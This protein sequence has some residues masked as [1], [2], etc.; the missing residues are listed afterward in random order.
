MQAK[1]DKRNVEDIISLTSMQEGMLFHYI[2]EPDSTEYH[3]QINIELSG[4]INL[5]L[6]KK[7]WSFV[8]ETNEMLRTIYRWKNIDKPVQ[9]V[10]KNHEVIIQNYNLSDKSSLEKERFLDEIK[11]VDLLNRIDLEKETLRI[12]LCKCAE[13]EYTM[14]ISNHHILYDGWS[15]AIIIKELLSVYHALHKGLVLEAPSK[16]KFKEYVK[17][18]HAQDKTK[19]KEYWEN[20]LCELEQNDV[21]FC[22]AEM[23]EDKN[24]KY[25]LSNAVSQEIKKF[26]KEN[27]ISV[28]AFLYC[29]WGILAQKLNNTRDILFGATTSGRSQYING[30]ENMVGLFINTIPMRINTDENET[31]IKLIKKT[32][33]ALQRHGEFE[34]TP[35]VDIKKY[36]KLSNTAQL[37][38]SL[39]VIENYPLDISDLPDE[40]LKITNY[41][42]IE[43]TNYNLT[44]GITIL[45]SID[46]D[47]QYKCFSDDGMIVR[48]AQYF[49]AVISAM[50][51]DKNS[52]IVD[53]EI[54]SE[55]ERNQ[56][57]YDFNDTC[58]EYPQ[59]K[60]IHKLFEEQVTKTPKNTAL[61]C[62]NEHMSY[63]ELNHRANRIASI[64]HTKGVGSDTIVGIMAERSFELIIGMLGVLKAGGAYVSIDPEYP[65]DRI[66]FMI[67]DSGANILLTQ[68]RFG[69]AID[70][71][72]ETIN[73]DDTRLYE[74]NTENLDI[75]NN[76]RDLAYIIYTSGSTG[77]PKGVMIEHR[78]VVNLAIGQIKTYK[79][80]ELDRVLQFYSASFDASVEQIFTTLL[81]GAALYLV[82]KDTL[83]NHSKFNALLKN[84]SITHLD[85][86]P[87]F[88]EN[89]NLDEI[90]SLKRVISGGEI[91]HSPLAK[92]LCQKLEFYNG[93]G[94]TEA[95][96]TSTMYLMNHNDEYANIP[97]GKPISN[98]QTYILNADGKPSPLGTPGE[99][100]IS[101]DGLAR[102]YLNNPEL[103]SEKFVPNPF[104]PN[105]R[106]YRTGDLAR[107]LPCGNIEFLGRV[108]HQ[109]K[110]RGFRIEIGEVESQLIALASVKEAAIAVKEDKYGNKYLCAYVV[111]N[112][113]ASVNELR[114]LLSKNLP[115]YMIPSHF[116]VINSL[117]LTSSGKIDRRALPEP[118]GAALQVE[119]VAPQN[120]TEEVLAKIWSEILGIE[121]VGIKDNFFDLGG[122]SL[123]GTILVSRI[124]KEFNIELPLKE[125]FKKPTIAEISEYILN[126]EE[127]LHLE[128]KPIESKEY[129]MTSAAQKRMWVLQQLDTNNTTYNMT[130]VLILDGILNKERLESTFIELIHRHEV[131]RTSFDMVDGN[132]V[133]RVTEKVDFNIKYLEDMEENIENQIKD[134]VQPFDLKKAPL[135]RASLIKTN[136]NQHFLLFDMHHIISDGVSVTTLTREFMALYDGQSFEAQKI[137]YK[138][139]AEWQNEFLKSE[140]VLKQEKY[141]LEQFAGEIPV[142]NLPLDY[143]RPA[144]QEFAGDSIKF[145]LDNELVEKLKMISKETGATLYM[146][147]LSAINIL[148]SKYSGQ[149]DIIIG[150]FI[151]GRPHA[152]LKTMLGMFINTIAMRNYPQGSK[153]YAEFLNDVKATAL[154]AYENQDYPFEDMVDKLNIH[155]DLSRTPLFD[156]IFVLQNMEAAELKLENL[157]LSEYIANQSKSQI[158]LYFDAKEVGNEILF[159]I[160]YRTSLFKRET[161]ERLCEHLQNVLEEISENSNMLLSDI[162]ILSTAERQKVLYEFN[163]TIME[164]PKDKTINQLF[165]DRVAEIP[166]KTALIFCDKVMTYG[167]LNAKA[168]QIARAL[169]R[170]NV[171]PDELVGIM[172]E[173]SFEMIIGILGILKAGGAYVPI[174]PEYPEDRIQFMLKDSGA[175]ILLTQS[176]LNEIVAFEGETINLDDDNVYCG[177]TTNLDIISDSSNLAYVLYTSGSTGVPKG[178]MME[179]ISTVNMLAGHENLYPVEAED[180]YLLKTAYTFDMGLT[181][182]FGWFIGDGKCVILE[183]GKEKEPAEILKIVLEKNI[184]HIRFVPSVLNMFMESV[185]CDSLS[186]ASSLKYIHVAG[187]A[188]SGNIVDK[189]YR[190][191][192]NVRIENIYGPTECADSTY[193]SANINDS[194]QNVPI[195]KPIQNYKI[196]ILDN[197]S[198]PLPIGIPG[199]L[200]IS[201]IG[202]ARGYLNRDELTS[203]KFVP[204]L[205]LSDEYMYRTGDLARWLPDGNIEFLG[206]IDHQVKIRGFRVEPGEIESCLL[207]LEFVKDAVVL[208]FEDNTGGKYLCAYIVSDEKIST[209]ELRICLSKSLPDYMIP[210]H[211]VHLESIPLTSNGKVDRK[212]LPLPIIDIGTE[213]VAPRDTIEETLARVWCEVL[214]REIVGIYDNFF[215]LGGHSLKGT[216]LVSRIHKELNVELPLKELFKAPTISGIRE[217]IKDA[218]ISVYSSIEPI[219]NKAYYETSSA[220]KRMFLLHQ[221][222]PNGIGYNMP[223][224][225]IL[226]GVLDIDQLKSVFMELINR[227]E[228]LRTSF[229]M[230][231]D[232]IVQKAHEEFSFEI[233][234]TEADENLTTEE[235]RNFIKPFDL[236]KAPLLRVGLVKMSENRHLLLFDMHHIISDGTS[237]VILTQ[238]FIEL[239]Q[240][241]KLEKLKIQYKDFAE[242]QNKFLKSK[243]MLA[244]E[245]Y[246][247]E[248]LSGEIPVLN[249]PLDYVRPAVKSFIGDKIR[250]VLDVDLTKKLRKISMETGTTL[251]MTLLSSINILLMQYTGQEDIIIGSPIAGRKHTDL[252]GIIG[253]FV[254]T[255][256]MRNYPIG[257]KTYAEFLKEVKETALQAFTNQDYQF[258]ELVDKLNLSRDLSRNPLFDVMFV[259]QNMAAANVEIDRLR[260]TGYDSN[261]A[262]AKFDLT[263]TAEEMDDEISFS[264]EYCVS[265][266]KRETIERMCGHLQRIFVE[267]TENQEI[268]LMDIDMLSPDERNRILYEFNNTYAEFPKDKTIHQLFEEQVKKTPDNVAL[269][270]EDRSITYSELNAKS[271]QLARMLRVSGVDS[272]GLVGI[273]VERSFEMIIGILGILKAGGAYV[274]IDPEYPEERIKFMLEDSEAE[275]LLTQSWLEDKI[276]FAGKKIALDEE[277]THLN[278][279]ANLEIINNPKNLACVIYTSGSTGAPKGVM[280][281][282]A[283]IV[284]MLF[285][286]ERKYPLLD[287]DAYLLKTPYTFDFSTSEIFG[288]FVG[289]G[290]LVILSQGDEKN[291]KEIFKAIINHDVTHMNLVTPMLNVFIDIISADE[292]NN[293]GRLKYLFVG[294]EALGINCVNKFYLAFKGA[295]LE[296]VY[297]PTETSYTTT[298]STRQDESYITTPIGKPMANYI[299]YILNADN[300]L[301]PLNI[302][303]E[304][305]I[306]GV[307]LA[308]GYLKRSELTDEKFVENPFVPGERMYRTGD[309]VRWLP[310]GNIEFLGRIDHQ[311]KIRGFRIELGEIESKLFE[312]E[313]VKEAVVL[314]HEDDRGDKYLCAYIATDEDI[315]VKELRDHLSKNLPD[316]MIPSYF[317]QLD[318]MPLTPN[319][320]TDRKALPAPEG[321]MILG[322]EYEAPRNQTEEILAGI[323]SEILGV[324]RIGIHDNFFELGGHSLKG[325]ILTSK[326]HKELNVEVPLKELFKSPTIARISEYIA[327]LTKSI[328]STIEPIEERE[329]YETSSAQ[330]RMWLLRQFD[331]EGTSYNMPGVFV[332]DGLLDMERIKSAFTGLIMRHEAL[333][334]SFEMIDDAIVQKIAE[335]VDFE[336]EYAEAAEENIDEEIKEFLHS[337]DLSKAPL[338]RVKV[339]R[340]DE[341]RHYLLFDMHHIISDGTSIAILM[342]EFMALYGGKKLLH[343]K[344]QYKDFSEWQNKLLKSEK[345]QIQEKYWLDKFADDIPILNLPLDYV[346]PIVQSFKGDNISFRLD[347]CL[348]K[349]LRNIS[350]ETGTTLYMILL[351]AI[352]ILLSKYTGQEDIIV[353]SPIAGRPHP[354]LENIIGMFV[355]TLAMRSY[356]SSEKS[357]VEFLDSVKEVAL[358]AYENQDYQFEEL[359]DKLNLSR[360]LSRNPLFDV[361]FVLQNMESVVL[362]IKNLKFTEYYG[363]QSTAKFD[364]TF[365]AL[366][367]KEELVLSIEYCTSLFKKDTIERMNKHL[368]NLLSAISEN[369]NISLGDIEIISEYERNLILHEF[370]DTYAEYPKDKTIHQLFEEQ[371]KKSPNNVAL[372]CENDK[373]SYSELN[374]KSNQ[375]AYTLR[376]KG[377]KPDSIV[378][379]MVERS[380]EM[381]IG[382]LGILKAGG[383]YVPIDPEYPEERIKFM[384]KDSGMKILLTQSH[385]DSSVI[386][387][388]EKINLDKI[389]LYEGTYKNLSTI[390]NPRDIAYVI[391]TSGSTGKPKGVIVEHGNIV[392]FINCQ[393]QRTYKMTEQDRVL[394]SSPISFDP[395]IEQIFIALLSGAS[396]YLIDTERLLDINKFHMF[397]R[398]NAITYLYHVPSYLKNINFEELTDLRVVVSGGEACPVSLAKSLNGKFE[399][400]NGYGPAEATVKSAMYL[401]NP[402]L[403]ETSVPIGKPVSNASIHIVDKNGKLQP[404]CIPGEICISGFGVARG[405]LNHP[406][407]TDEKFVSNPF[408]PNERMYCTGD[409]AKW[410]PDGNIEFLGRID[411]Q[412][413]IRGFRIELGEIEN[414]LL[415]MEIVKEAIILAKEDESG[416]KCLCAYIVV[417]E[418]IAVSEVQ[419]YLSQNLPNYMIPSYIVKLENMPLNPSGKVDR[420]LLPEPK[421]DTDTRYVAPRNE[422]EKALVSIWREV[423]NRDC[424][425]I[426][427]NF[428]EIGGDSIKAILI[429]SKLRDAGYQLR[430]TDLMTSSIF[431]LANMHVKRLSEKIIY[432]QGEIAG[433]SPLTPIQKY[434]L[435]FR[436]INKNHFNQAM[437]LEIMEHVK[438][439][440]IIAVLDAIV[441]HHDIFRAVYRNGEQEILSSHE[442]IGYELFVY[443]YSKLSRTDLAQEI[444]K[445]NNEIQSSI[446]I[447]KGPLMK[448]GLFRTNST[449]HFMIC[450]HHLISDGVSRR[451]LAEDFNTGLRQCRLGLEICL[452][453]KTASYKDWGEELRDYC[454]SKELLDEV[455]Y[456]KHIVN[457][458]EK[459]RIQKG[460]TGKEGVGHIRVSLDKELTDKLLYKS[461][462]IYEVGI[463][464]ILLSSLGM[465]IRRLTSQDKLGVNLVGHGRETINKK[466]ELDRTVGWF[467]IAYP[468][469]IEAKNNLKEVIIETKEMLR[470]IPNKGIGYGALFLLHEAN[471]NLE[472]ADITLNYMGSYDEILGEYSTIFRTSE[473]STGMS[474]ASENTQKVAININGALVNEQLCFDIFY[475]KEKL[476]DKEAKRFS[477]LYRE[478]LGDAINA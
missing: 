10:L 149:E 389:N 314:A 116:I 119:Y 61:V 366:E 355:N 164:Y 265:L 471:F 330:K 94:P 113:G 150:S 177:G 442:A 419:R 372:V 176:W 120:E 263:F 70:F 452:G 39:V 64:L 95:T 155:R 132:I 219:E 46:I 417:S 435:M 172:V 352:S 451:I 26:A 175:R 411:H 267:I 343:Q 236:E 222:D 376:R 185:G 178:V 66:K 127:N 211:F 198:K 456:W 99:L 52:K 472:I 192:P 327:G 161:I 163:D 168:N 462:K 432:D 283:A 379:I 207:E 184:S 275:I 424:I 264:V 450:I 397:M 381:I 367:D 51:S 111:L 62:E 122:H 214:N 430:F 237:M 216:T 85:A 476:T 235:I 49:D 213:Y 351:S 75:S 329:Y 136:E 87:T 344:I 470:K 43:R 274:P 101:G 55:D 280:L 206:R 9:V 223:G 340:T 437:M 106:M 89:L 357:Y 84:G 406:E 45:D 56:I 129:Y 337:F 2:M 11:Q 148:L 245:D 356:P 82:D 234:Y 312:F 157:K 336:V 205:L 171:K 40:A 447:E 399:A 454:V 298:Y 466:I 154:N 401:I 463:P 296:N 167:E 35:L 328:Y 137:Q 331:S 13:C 25:S 220:Q 59:D 128:I 193:Y 396:L 441:K 464:C 112:D 109:V 54:L 156:V 375:L 34:S 347:S 209:S 105:S 409:L 92:L 297:G 341:N 425:G 306:S 17:L 191:L 253:M 431:D 125:L 142:L 50:I 268:L 474:I 63:E 311:V 469:I 302:P 414:Q 412:V 391:Y 225:L 334:T 240:G 153:T 203:E 152:D 29:A 19:Q 103:T 249:L 301:A 436:A 187:E 386:F 361:M 68:T 440:E 269:V 354:D 370:N 197:N 429:I 131:L 402:K 294:G 313:E 126:A 147:L 377:V 47:F 90:D 258:E 8:I 319:G 179:H 243:N 371:V 359:V 41:S 339:I 284:N 421:G 37:F 143:T 233:E 291:P 254:N 140:S 427:D 433:K 4:E 24:Y 72:C 91:C 124:H 31:A 317:T 194:L 325:T 121:K 383:A 380:F 270:F 80:N 439:E 459:C 100:C 174:D 133:Q 28:S 308:R 438:T 322:A 460:N 239:Y 32:N 282:H 292:I 363:A 160:R 189:L 241:K 144:T 44:L 115:D 244:Q 186:K 15:S 289:S 151:D 7:A 251:Y 310:D 22:N 353:G 114:D 426:Y 368:L 141:W 242:W 286:M 404:L 183:P 358:S 273:M 224:A 218:E 444:E 342:N 65:E 247:L 18:A 212:A 180:V 422:R 200:Y 323:W 246:W 77:M 102:G 316:Y 158:D 465:A 190:C 42:A 73:L 257:D 384:L 170:N 98:Y 365:F 12:V 104:I 362:E 288:W 134:F 93:Y 261:Q 392:N 478:T 408:F 60:T 413:K 196:Y 318:V 146:F 166:E 378:G 477:E 320:K 231:D 215:D 238:E 27:G 393:I 135:I 350:K 74:G 453:E 259:L 285:G 201:G 226:D 255:L 385:L 461:N 418:D 123:K 230:I 14:V 78:S 276:E 53:I 21:L 277:L 107:W 248:Q 390:S 88:L 303:G 348:T 445:R 256:V 272:D 349:K 69:N 423:L 295:M 1:L 217:Y 271:N 405:Y 182:L 229:Y 434:F 346:R 373:M 221:L 97:I 232:S 443:D 117:P 473:Y 407:L 108:D 38:N 181:E 165:E 307:G 468:V 227:H 162:N 202:V 388:G 369:K 475:K 457:E 138:D 81:C 305:C 262:P 382:I 6:F 315:D 279:E 71:E 169:R 36:A 3:E 415:E 139:F 416:D 395:S 467:T 48:I 130:Q 394:Q 58:V 324:E 449:D 67:K 96:I 118:E 345:I 260:F 338:L 321:G 455:E 173:R 420:E 333:R 57:L 252:E 278:V 145:S 360:D 250:F 403:I 204:D 326:I 83:L 387:C 30:I 5:D 210:S 110:I 290:K 16:N 208:T 304:L 188:L 410:L 335:K 23:S 300:K 281:T 287:D 332:M 20:Y 228:S 458:V 79:M 374:I 428:F 195:G 299:T 309:L 446:N 159:N 199:E 293:L 86:T 266:F 76:P 398:N 364:L 448:A 33:E 400:Y